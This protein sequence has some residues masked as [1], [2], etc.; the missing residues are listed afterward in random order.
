MPKEKTTPKSELEFFT[1]EDGQVYWHFTAP[2]GREVSDGGQG[3]ADLDN[4]Q[5]GFESFRKD[6]AE[7]NYTTKINVEG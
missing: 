6:V 5:A 7:G 3:Y 2:N 1:G 4:A